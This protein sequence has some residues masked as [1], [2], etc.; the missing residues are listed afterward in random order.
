MVDQGL[1]TLTNFAL[2][3][4]IARS[5]DSAS[6]GAFAVGYVAYYTVIAGVRGL[7]SLPL[8][9]RVS[10]QA[11]QTGETSA[12]AGAAALVGVVAGLVLAVSGMALRS[13]TGDVLLVFGLLMPGLCL[14]DTWRYVFFTT[15]RPTLAVR[16][17]LVWVVAQTVFIALVIVFVD[18][19]AVV[20]FA[21]AWG[22]AAL[23]AACYGVAQ[24]QMPAWRQA[25]AFLRRHWD[26][27]ARLSA[28]SVLSSGSA[29]ITTLVIGGIVGP[30]GVGSIRGASTLFG[31]LTTLQ[32]GIISAAIPE[33]SRAIKSR[34]AAV[35]AA[36]Q[37]IS[38]GGAA[39]TIVWGAALWVLPE[40]WGRQV[41]GDTWHGAHAVLVPVLALMVG[42]AVMTGGNVGLKVLEAAQA[43]LSLLIVAVL[44]S[45]LGALIGVW[46][47][48]LGGAAWGIAAGGW[49]H[50]VGSW[51]TFARLYRQ[52][53]EERH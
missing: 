37:A 30:A 27:G 34:P 32:M 16:N 2:T 13:Q 48:G 19:A 43:S 20:W 35:P 47:G 41:L 49:V 8:S 52:G 26:L 53:A 42:R 12:G 40:A 6:F 45:T 51:S 46:I 10:R 29:M 39:L 33:G 4:V 21:V 11:E 28:E 44:V 18:D 1:S 3:I 9:I 15:A 17:D 24:A 7:V 22:G 5:V 25:V 31:P 23:V 14:Q 36:L 50:A 38:A